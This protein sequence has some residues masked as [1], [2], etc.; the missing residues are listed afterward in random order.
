VDF[1]LLGRDGALVDNPRHYRDARNNGMLERTF[2]VAPRE[3]VF[4]QTGIQ[5]M[6]FNSLYQLHAIKLA[7]PRVLEVA[8]RLLFMPDLFTYWLSGAQVSELSI[9]STS[10]FYNPREKRWP[11]SCSPSWACPRRYWPISCRRNFAGHAAAARGGGHRLQFAP[12]YATCGHDTA[13]AVAAVP[14]AGDD[15]VYI[16][17]GTWSLMA[18]SWTPGRQRR[19]AGAELHHEIG[20]NGSIR[21]LKNIAGLWLLQECRRAWALAG[22][23]TV[24]PSW[25][26]WLRKPGLCRRDRSGRFPRT[27]RHAREDRGF[28]RFHGQAAPQARRK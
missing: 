14:A 21:F 6:Q 9:A 15:W 26:R 8:A 23:S 17:S 24:T 20:V 13:S 28:L 1:G 16:S 22:R 12:V 25:P 18:W 27:G 19:L 11:P 4:A 10:Q 5:F 2:A 3:E 7:A